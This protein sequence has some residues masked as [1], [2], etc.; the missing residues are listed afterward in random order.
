MRSRFAHTQALGVLALALL[1]LAPATA[2]AAPP[3][4]MIA[5]AS[6]LTFTTAQTT[7]KVN[8]QGKER[9]CCLCSFPAAPC[10]ANG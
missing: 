8:P 4:V 10:I 5:A 3:A 6:G 7:G 1:A 2:S 9:A